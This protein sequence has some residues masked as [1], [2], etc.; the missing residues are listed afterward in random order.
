MNL[1]EVIQKLQT[2]DAKDLKNIDFNDLKNRLIEKQENL[3]LFLLIIISV[4]ATIYC[5]SQYINNSQKNHNKIALLKEQL[6]ATDET[7]ITQK[8]YDEFIKKFPNS[9]SINE[10]GDKLTE[11]SL[12]RNIKILSYS[13]E[14][15][16]ENEF[17]QSILVHLMISSNE[18]KNI[19]NFINDVE[20][21]PYSI[22]LQ[23]VTVK[24]ISENLSQ[25]ISSEET[26]NKT[27][28]ADI[29]LEAISLKK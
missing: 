2:I 16:K 21:A 6:K 18:Y 13:P 8:D 28:K 26:K 7:K 15:Q 5:L 3:I 20:E 9:I 10:L 29:K 4:F 22:R 27:T 17:Y 23:E 19:I 12:K 25:N 14:K 24:L 11:F 1:K